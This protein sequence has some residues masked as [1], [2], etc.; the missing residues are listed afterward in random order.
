MKCAARCAAGRYHIWG[1][2]LL[3]VRSWSARSRLQNS[4][5]GRSSPSGVWGW[6]A[7]IS[8]FHSS[9]DAGGH[10]SSFSAGLQYLGRISFSS[11][12]CSRVP[13]THKQIIWALLGEKIGLA[14]QARSGYAFRCSF[15]F[16]PAATGVCPKG[17][18]YKTTSI[19]HTGR[20]CYNDRT[21]L[22]CEQFYLGS[23]KGVRGERHTQCLSCLLTGQSGNSISLSFPAV[24]RWWMT[25][26]FHLAQL[27]LVWIYSIYKCHEISSSCS[28]LQCADVGGDKQK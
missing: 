24:R 22:K 10:F 6:P 5:Q 4:P 17:H 12:R 1:H 18:I 8:L 13:Y 26:C 15:I 25:A 20:A 2:F 11:L 21:F 9:T 14:K 27:Q 19:C 16:F 7:E 3:L 28:R 23:D